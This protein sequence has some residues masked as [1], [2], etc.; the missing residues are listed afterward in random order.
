MIDYTVPFHEYD[1]EVLPEYMFIEIPS[2]NPGRAQVLYYIL[3]HCSPGSFNGEQAP[4]EWRHYHNT[5]FQAPLFDSTSTL[6]STLLTDV[7]EE[8]MEL[9]TTMEHP[10]P[11]HFVL[12]FTD[13]EFVLSIEKYPQDTPA[14]VDYD[15]EKETCSSYIISQEE[16]IE[17]LR[18]MKNSYL[19]S[20]TGLIVPVFHH[21]IPAG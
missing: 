1:G 5:K 13:G 12:R 21:F 15:Y 6:G 17:Y 16:A 8:F 3:T 9:V 4:W 19:C 2:F 10:D 14:V 20:S 18:G 7:Y 11:P